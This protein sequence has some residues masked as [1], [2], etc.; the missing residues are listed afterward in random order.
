M[1]LDLMLYAVPH[2][3][4]PSWNMFNDERTEELAYGRKAWEI[5]NFF[6]AAEEPYYHEVSLEDW[7]AFIEQLE[8][9][10]G[11]FDA[12]WNAFYKYENMPEDFGEYILTDD[13][14]RLIAEYEYWYNETWNDTPTLSYFFSV[15]YMKEFWLANEKVKEYSANGYDIYI[16]ASY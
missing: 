8:P 2:T 11:K 1:G 15:G 13:D 5:C 4:E 14:K 16:E 6:G 7:E 9:I 10:S 12:I 3:E